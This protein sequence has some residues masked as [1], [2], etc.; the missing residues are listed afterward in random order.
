MIKVARDPIAILALA[1]KAHLVRQVALELEMS[2]EEHPVLDKP[3]VI[4]FRFPPMTSEDESKLIF[5]VPR[6][7][8]WQAV[9]V[10]S[11]DPRKLDF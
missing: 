1:S 11:G 10:G 3:D 8:F 9:F 6:E 7:A 4:R 5:A 2:Y